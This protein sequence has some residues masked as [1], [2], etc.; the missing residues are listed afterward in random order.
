MYAKQYRYFDTGTITV[1]KALPAEG[2]YTLYYRA[3][4]WTSH[5]STVPVTVTSRSGATKTIFVNCRASSAA[6][7]GKYPWVELGVFELRELR[8][9]VGARSGYSTFSAV[10]AVKSDCSTGAADCRGKFN[11]NYKLNGHAGNDFNGVDIRKVA[12]GPGTVRVKDQTCGALCLANS[13]CEFWVRS[14]ETYACTASTGIARESCPENPGA[15]TWCWLKKGFTGFNPQWGNWRRGNFVRPQTNIQK[16]ILSA[17]KLAIEAEAAASYKAD[18]AKLQADKAKMEAGVADAEAKKAQD[19][20][21]FAKAEAQKAKKAVADAK[22]G[23]E[24]Y[25]RLQVEHENLA[26]IAA[27][28]AE[29]AIRLTE[30]AKIAREAATAKAN[31][32]T[33][34]V[35]ANKA[36]KDA[37]TAFLVG[38]NAQIDARNAKNAADKLKR[39][40]RIEF[41]ANKAARVQLARQAKAAKDEADAAK[42]QGLLNA[43]EAVK[44]E[45]RA[46]GQRK[47]DSAAAKA[48][49]NTAAASV[50]TSAY[51]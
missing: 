41:D 6:D 24:R 46:K 30:E 12:T 28:K 42:A 43:E 8:I 1:I 21:D 17:N 38:Q 39:E 3:S 7:N 16:T 44:A 50:R 31:A 26:R 5:S 22:P 29:H 27:E 23:S 25:A 2:K 14:V 47:I 51:V 13:L 18:I 4:L 35:K 45:T 10:K 15:S 32:H 9:S 49:A 48:A 34:Q 19:A 20:A 37:H 33:A 11:S 40:Q 36:E